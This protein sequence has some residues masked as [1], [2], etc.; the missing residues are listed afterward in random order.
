MTN[1]NSTRYYK[2]RLWKITWSYVYAAKNRLIRT[3]KFYF[4]RASIGAPW[5]IVRAVVTESEPRKDT[6]T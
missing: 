1:R 2:R 5:S 3:V 6:P 4:R